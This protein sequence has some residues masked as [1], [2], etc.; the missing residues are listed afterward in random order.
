MTNSKSHTI[1]AVTLDMPLFH[2]NRQDRRVQAAA[3][4]AEAIKT[5]KVLLQRDM[6]AAFAAERKQLARL[7]DRQ[8]LYQVRLLP[9]MHEQARASLAAYTNDDG[10]FAEVVRARIAELN[11]QIE[12][13]GIDVAREKTIAR[14]NYF[15]VEAVADDGSAD[16]D[17]EGDRP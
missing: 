11:A 14:L 17:Y 9:Q 4:E 15:L 2:A 8:R 5:E 13:L 12:A 7:D 6:V 1:R 3:S 16:T 10:D